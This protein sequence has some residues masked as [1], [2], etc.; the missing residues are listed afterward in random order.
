M[1]VEDTKPIPAP[2]DVDGVRTVALGTVLY[3][4]AAA[5]TPFVASSE[6]AWTCVAGFLLGIV[7]VTYCV[8]RRNAASHNSSARDSL[9]R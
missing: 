3:G 7:G 8:R 5:I 9:A 6:V 4:V 1:R 2:L